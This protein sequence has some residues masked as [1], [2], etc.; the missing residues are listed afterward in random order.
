MGEDTARPV[1]GGTVTVLTGD[2]PQDE[3]GPGRHRHRCE[4]KRGESRPEREGLFDGQR[5]LGVADVRGE[6]LVRVAEVRRRPPA[7]GR[8][9]LS[10]TGTSGLPQRG[11]FIFCAVAS[12]S[13]PVAGSPANRWNF[14]TASWVP[15]SNV[16]ALTR[17]GLSSTV[18]TSSSS[19][20]GKGGSERFLR[21]RAEVPEVFEVLLDLLHIIAGRTFV[22]V[23]LDPRPS[24]HLVPLHAT[25]PCRRWAPNVVAPLSNARRP[26][27]PELIIG[28]CRHADV[29]STSPRGS[30][31]IGSPGSP[32]PTR[33]TAEGRNPP[34]GRWPDSRLIRRAPWG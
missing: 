21:I 4:P 19:A 26:L 25:L 8:R 18:A 11:S 16:P 7:P 30:E 9:E 32:R 13:V 29:S 12:S 31:G 5:D 20:S 28:G 23:R 15:L 1:E 14:R 10:E 24:R 22:E 34:D 33:S 2:E 6:V 27:P 17:A 3:F